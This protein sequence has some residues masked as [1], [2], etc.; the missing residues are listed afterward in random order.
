ME[1]GMNNV[2]IDGEHLTLENVLEV[3]ERR[4]RVRISPSVEKKVKR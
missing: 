3:A 1:N 2:T 4:A